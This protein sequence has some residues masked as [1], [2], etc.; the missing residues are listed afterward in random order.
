MIVHVIGEGYTENTAPP[1][2]TVI[3]KVTRDMTMSQVVSKIISQ[4]RKNGGG[5]GSI[6]LLRI[7]EHGNAGWMSLGT[8]LKPFT[9][10]PFKDLVPWMKQNGPGVEL[11]GCNVGSA[12]LLHSI[13]CPRWGT[14][15]PKNAAG[16]DRGLHLM[17][18]LSDLLKVPI[19]AGIDCQDPD[20][21]FSLEGRTR[22][23]HTHWHIVPGFEGPTT[24]VYPK[25]GA[26]DEFVATG[27]LLQVLAKNL[28]I[29][30]QP[31]DLSERIKILEDF[32]E[33]TQIPQQTRASTIPDLSEKIRILDFDE[34]PLVPPQ[35]SASTIRDPVKGITIL[36]D[37][38]DQ[39]KVPQQIHA[40]IKDDRMEDILQDINPNQHQVPQPTYVSIRDDRMEDVLQDINP[41]QLQVPQPTYASLRDNRIE[42]ALQNINPNQSQVPQPTYTSMLDNP[43][44]RQSSVLTPP[45]TFGPSQSQFESQN[46]FQ[47]QHTSTTSGS[48]QWMQ[49]MGL[50]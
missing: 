26:P 6:S 20:P 35:S 40:S 47:S 38:D 10:E 49:Q 23:I 4:V 27:N 50:G 34:Q 44:S 8:G 30:E 21:A 19:T 15:D 48:P 12:D 25:N 16:Y 18:K 7:F 13:E 28:G 22:T 11:H 45:T 1:P 17:T 43:L 46:S 42:D 9:A 5:Y 29:D 3:V 24:I 39:T 36:E 14:Y 33:Q 32:D 31:H 37:L 2:S 41:N